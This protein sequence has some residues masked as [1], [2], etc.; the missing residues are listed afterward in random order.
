MFNNHKD[1]FLT[2]LGLKFD[3]NSWMDV[4]TRLKYDGNKE[5]RTKKYYASTLPLFAGSDMGAYYKDEVSTTQIYADAMLNVDKYIGDFS[6]MA[7]LGAS[8]RD[9][10]YAFSSLGGPLQRRA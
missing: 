8:I 2:G 10:Q 9:V 3:I 1:R 5:T 6:L 7:T 4:S